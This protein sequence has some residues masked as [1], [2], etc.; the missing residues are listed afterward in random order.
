MMIINTVTK[1]RYGNI[2]EYRSDRTPGKDYG[3]W[4]E[5]KI[6]AIKLYQTSAMCSDVFM[7]YYEIEPLELVG[8]EHDNEEWVLE[9]VNVLRK[10]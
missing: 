2:V 1:Y 4:R 3:K 7:I 8:S 10:P 9:N 5:G 6:L